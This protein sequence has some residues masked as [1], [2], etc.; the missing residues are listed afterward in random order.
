MYELFDFNIIMQPSTIIRHKVKK[1]G[2]ELTDGR[3]L[4]YICVLEGIIKQFSN[5]KYKLMVKIILNR[6]VFITEDSEYII[7]IQ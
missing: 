6:Y 5:P 7:Q 4:R 3:Q 1:N 2:Y